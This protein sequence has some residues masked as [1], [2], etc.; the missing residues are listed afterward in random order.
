MGC[1]HIE[2]TSTQ[3]S[4]RL[5]K[6]WNQPN[7]RSPFLPSACALRVCGGLHRSEIQRSNPSCRGA[8]HTHT[9][10]VWHSSLPAAAHTRP[11]SS[12]GLACTGRIS[13]TLGIISCVDTSWSPCHGHGCCLQHTC[14]QGLKSGGSSRVSFS[15]PGVHTAQVK[16][17]H[18]RAQ[19]ALPNHC[20]T[21]TDR[22]A[23]A[24]LANPCLPHARRQLLSAAGAAAS[25]SGTSSLVRMH[26]GML[27]GGYY[28][29]Q[30]RPS[31]IGCGCCLVPP[32]LSGH[33]SAL[34][35]LAAPN[36]H[37]SPT[38]RRAP[39]PLPPAR[40][41]RHSRSHSKMLPTPRWAMGGGGG[42]GSKSI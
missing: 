15:K 7:K 39:T 40:S 26:A 13:S 27:A 11:L 2:Q 21:P 17:P 10:C 5:N 28:R 38:S 23:G 9:L 16:C 3:L 20:P 19:S 33:R 32:E 12:S 8:S 6:S 1:M 30:A 22:P 25:I 24:L 29:P 35:V 4:C 34:S 31:H 42:M 14:K 41:A 36:T 18:T 37:P